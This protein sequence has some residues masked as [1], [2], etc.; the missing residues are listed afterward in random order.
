MPARPTCKKLSDRFTAGPL[1]ATCSLF[2]HALLGA[3][4][5]P[6]DPPDGALAIV[7]MH[8]RAR[9]GAA[10]DPSPTIAAAMSVR[11]APPRRS[12]THRSRSAWRA[13]SVRRSTTTSSSSSCCCRRSSP[14][15]GRWPTR[16][17]S[18]ATCRRLRTFSTSWS[19][20]SRCGCTHEYSR[21]LT[22]AV[23]HRWGRRCAERRAFLPPAPLVRLARQQ[24]SLARV[25]GVM[26]RRCQCM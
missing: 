12:H 4:T 24:G 21:V 19:C 2:A 15:S 3:R 25:P 1:T 5:I 18:R 20:C 26:G 11:C 14:P 23:G 8:A 6:P 10:R 13:L 9:V 7:R 22:S 17:P 16:T